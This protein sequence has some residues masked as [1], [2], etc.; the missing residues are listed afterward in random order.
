V[1]VVSVFAC[2][3]PAEN[4]QT[5]DLP[6]PPEKLNTAE[7]MKRKALG[8]SGERQKVNVRNLSGRWLT[9]LLDVRM[10]SVKG[11]PDSTSFISART[12]TFL[13]RL[14]IQQMEYWFRDNGAYN[15][16]YRDKG[17]AIV[18]T[19]NGNWSLQGTTLVLD[20]V[21]PKRN[22]FYYEFTAPFEEDY[23]ARLRGVLDYDYDGEDDDK[24]IMVLEKMSE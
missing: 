21:S 10:T 17:D 15:I 12:G 6:D 16:I 2:Q 9:N 14:G 1:L 13:E 24:V 8:Q 5:G 22:T 11:I 3:T 18:R 7:A 23:Q 4:A 19:F 20:E